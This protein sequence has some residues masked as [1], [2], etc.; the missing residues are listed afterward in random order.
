[1][2]TMTTTTA[3]EDRRSL[4]SLRDA[5]TDTEHRD[6]AALAELADLR[7]AEQEAVAA[8]DGAA[9]QHIWGRRQEI[10]ARRSRLAAERAE[11]ERAAA[12]RLDAAVAG[13]EERQKA[14]VSRWQAE[15]R[16]VLGA[17]EAAVAAFTGAVRDLEHL[18]E[19]REAER[20]SLT[21]ELAALR[22]DAQGYPY[23]WP[24]PSWRVAP[25][26]LEPALLRFDTVARPYREAIRLRR[27]GVQL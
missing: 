26:D 5:L 16:A 8:Q 7:Q 2:A 23:P 25:A 18:P 11:V 13:W 12:A 17:V 22:E 14:A 15:Q 21:E 1:M 10:D 27:A 6:R 3:T 24:A 20:D 19:G 4:A 9:L